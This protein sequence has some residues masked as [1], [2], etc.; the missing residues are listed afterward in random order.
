M[1]IA[2][3]VR[4]TSSKSA[5][6]PVPTSSMP[7]SSSSSLPPH[8]RN[9]SNVAASKTRPNTPMTSTISALTRSGGCRCRILRTAPIIPQV[10]IAASTIME[11]PEVMSAPFAA[12]AGSS[13][14]RHTAHKFPAY[15]A[16][17]TNIDAQ[18]TSKVSLRAS[19][20]RPNCAQLMLKKSTSATTSTLAWLLQ[21][22]R[23]RQ[24]QRSSSAGGSLYAPSTSSADGL[25]AS[26]ASLD[27]SRANCGTTCASRGPWT[28]RRAKIA[29]SLCASSPCI[30][31]V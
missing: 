16:L 14:S 19:N 20:A 5:S 7:A 23:R 10:V 18:S 29:V 1:F 2:S 9:A 3:A 17:S 22:A 31:P 15:V 26:L 8:A 21:R 28:W 12:S 30:L 27:T 13:V 11:T 25:P 4:P 6:S 24:Q